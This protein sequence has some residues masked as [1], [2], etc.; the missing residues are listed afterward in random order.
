[1]KPTHANL[2][3]AAAKA[4]GLPV[5]HVHRAVREYLTQAFEATWA[6]GRVV[7]AGFLTLRTGKHKAR[8]LLN[9][10]TGEPMELPA[11]RVMAARVT[12]HWRRRRG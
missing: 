2:V 10:N 5:A 3:A 7:V 12:K 11:E 1:M 9:P 4:S 8:R 6:T